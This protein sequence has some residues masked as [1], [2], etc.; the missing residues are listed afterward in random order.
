MIAGPAERWVILALLI[1]SIAVWLFVLTACQ[2][3]LR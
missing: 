1:A 3:P 2:V